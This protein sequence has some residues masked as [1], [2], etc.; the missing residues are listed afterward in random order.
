MK[1]LVRTPNWLGDCIMALPVFKELRKAFP[2]THIT[3][4]CRNHLKDC[5]SADPNINDVITVPASSAGIKETYSS[6]QSLKE[7]NFN[8]G[9]LLTNSFGSALWLR[10]A[11]I[12]KRI[13]YKRDFRS[14]LLN[15]SF[16]AS[17]EIKA[18]HQGQY[19]L[20]LLNGFGID[21]QMSNPELFVSD[22][23]KSDAAALN[24]LGISGKFAVIAPFSAYGAVKD[25][26]IE[27]YRKVAE[28]I[29]RELSMEVV[30]TGTAAQNE[31]CAQLCAGNAAIHNAAG[32]TG[33]AGFM[34]ILERAS[35]FVGGDSGGAHTAAA[36]KVPTVT[37]FGITEPS[38]TRAMGEKVAIIG[39]GGL[40]TPNLRDPKIAAMAREALAQISAEEVFTAARNLL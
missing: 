20:H 37:I 11:G 29:S 23:G 35:L 3:A 10:M 31:Q 9:V 18:A 39:K 19:Y 2:S 7:H 34:G 5:F 13:G 25:W 22:A 15:C 36:L 16:H 26:H 38:R 6:S 27:N 21:A 17:K 8:A 40:E 14:L 1:I 4:A 33:L 30:I 32:L 28:M 24:K 12:T